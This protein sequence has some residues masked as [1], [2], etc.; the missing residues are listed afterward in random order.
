MQ[1]FQEVQLTTPCS[2]C[3]FHFAIVS[4]L[5]SFVFRIYKIVMLP[6]EKA[7]SLICCSVVMLQ[8][9]GHSLSSES[10]PLAVDAGAVNVHDPHG[11]ADG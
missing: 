5:D 10:S 6:Q 1:Y 2:I 7:A 4:R 9:A 8:L 3:R 11:K